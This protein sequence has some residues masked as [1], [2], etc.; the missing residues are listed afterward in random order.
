MVV[1][2][3]VMNMGMKVFLG[4]RAFSSFGCIH[5][6]GIA[7]PCVFHGEYTILQFHQ[8]CTNIPVSPHQHLI[9]FV[10]G[11]F[12]GLFICIVV[13]LLVGGDISLWF[14]LAFL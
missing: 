7:E 9:F 5:K 1:N 12:G 8:Q 4:C 13:I 2:N 3:S 11:F 10:L 14:G 6:S